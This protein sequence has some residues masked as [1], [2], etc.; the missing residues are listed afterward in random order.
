MTRT[1]GAA[2]AGLSLFLCC[3]CDSTDHVIF[4]TATNI[5]INADAKTQTA[6]IGYDRT[7][8]VI[9]PTYVDGGTLPGTF[10]YMNSNLSV[11]SPSVK[12][13][14]ATGEAAA[15]VTD[16]NRPLPPSPPPGVGMRRIMF[17]G[18]TSTIG[19]KVGFSTGTPDSIVLGY[20]RREL[21]VI[22]L[23]KDNP[24]SGNPDVYPPVIASIDMNVATPSLIETTLGL[25]QYFATGVAAVNVA[26]LPDIRAAFAAAAS[27]AVKK[28]LALADDT[29]KQA[30]TVATCV[31][32]SA[33][34][35]DAA[36]AKRR[37]AFA[38]SAVA[39]GKLSAAKAALF[40]QAASTQDLNDLITGALMSDAPALDQ[41]ATQNKSL[42]G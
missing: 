10:A 22:P 23:H 15:Q 9:G 36:A 41:W 38:D 33:G 29:K 8:G 24:D 32:P 34:T 37:D 4:V 21:S 16:T 39:G 35:F 18:T 30:T 25:T 27:D 2:I 3:G 40:K 17:F 13:L 42:C 1:R 5:G 28:G 26:R 20:K 7:E 12:Q 31:S 14:Y 11:F 19:L 6:N